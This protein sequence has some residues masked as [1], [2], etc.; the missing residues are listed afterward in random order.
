MESSGSS[1]NDL[2]TIFKVAHPRSGSSTILSQVKLEF[3]NA[4]F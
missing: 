2:I 4:G 1:D 3:E